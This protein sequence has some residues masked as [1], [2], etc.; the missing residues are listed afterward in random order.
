MFRCDRGIPISD[1][2]V[3]YSVTFIHIVIIKN[4]TNG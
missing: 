3:G 1:A 2:D 4:S